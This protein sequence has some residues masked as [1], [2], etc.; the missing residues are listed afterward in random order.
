VRPDPH[1]FG[2]EHSTVHAS[3]KSA[4]DKHGIVEI[5][6]KIG[7][8]MHTKKIS[9]QQAVAEYQAFIENI[10]KCRKNYALFI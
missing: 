2:N 9:H 3:E 8:G 4:Y 5:K 1:R 10:E 6:E 7:A